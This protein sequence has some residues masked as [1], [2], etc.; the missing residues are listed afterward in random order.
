M[1]DIDDDD[2]TSP[3]DQR[4]AFTA[5]CAHDFGGVYPS[6]PPTGS[7]S[8]RSVPLP[9]NYIH[10][11]AI[12]GILDSPIVLTKT[13]SPLS[14]PPTITPPT[15]A[16]PD[17][18]YD[19]S[20][21]L[22]LPIPEHSTPESHLLSPISPEW[23]SHRPDELFSDSTESASVLMSQ[24]TGGYPVGAYVPENDGATRVSDSLSPLD[25]HIH[26]DEPQEDPMRSS[27][28][29]LSEFDDDDATTPS[30]SSTEHD[31]FMPSP[32][33]SPEHLSPYH[34]PNVS[35][36]ELDVDDSELDG[37]GLGGLSWLHPSP[38][39]LAFAS[40]PSPE[41]DDLDID[42]D[43]GPGPGSSA[44]PS[45]RSVS[46][47]PLL[48]EDPSEDLYDHTGADDSIPPESS[49]N[50]L[51]LDLPVR[52]RTKPPY[53][54]IL[55]GFT[56]TELA[57]RLPA[58]LSQTE[59]DALLGVRARAQ[60]AL[61]ECRNAAS[62]SSSA[63][64]TDPSMRQQL[65]VKRKRAKQLCRETDALVGLELGII[66]DSDSRAADADADVRRSCSSKYDYAGLEQGLRSLGH[67]LAE[68]SSVPQ[69]AAR[70]I[71]RRR[72]RSMRRRLEGSVAEGARA[73]RGEVA[74]PLRRTVDD[75]DDELWPTSMEVD[76]A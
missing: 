36:R 26:H 74:S 72:E 3:D 2:G 32:P 50:A 35:L 21:S 76:A 60:A 66:P 64:D 53:V 42:M 34:S 43:L 16:L 4:F 19:A 39:L 31:D 11:F 62:A 8:S 44:S 24:F 1:M 57:A 20:L 25:L 63:A 33:L 68:L 9:M 15:R 75:D 45:R 18:S 41:L 12:G 71:L 51:C 30:M 67:G 55:D 27:L 22:L 14:P 49:P 65:K 59:L 37:L 28:L 73:R 6:P 5:S 61:A 13:T 58:N 54:S 48:E 38:K 7:Q 47:L 23:P 69:L 40:L 70:M 10:P 46:S 29:G 17:S 52:T 56:T